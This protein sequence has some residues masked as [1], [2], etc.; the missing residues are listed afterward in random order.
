MKPEPSVE[1]PIPASSSTKG[2][3]GAAPTSKSTGAS[4]KSAFL[5][6]T[7]TDLV[8]RDR[9]DIKQQAVLDGLRLGEKLSSI[10][11]NRINGQNQGLGAEE[12]ADWAQQFG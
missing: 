7:C 8:E 5:W 12:L 4:Q 2:G 3:A 6:K 10:L 9:V 11:K 1:E